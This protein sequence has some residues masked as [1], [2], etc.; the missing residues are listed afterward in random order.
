MADVGGGAGEWWSWPASSSDPSSISDCV[1]TCAWAQYRRKSN[2]SDGN[3][4]A[5]LHC[6]AN[7]YVVSNTGSHRYTHA[8]GCPHSYADHDSN[9]DLNSF[10]HTDVDADA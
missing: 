7:T 3:A 8:D 1:S 5:N 2:G 4:E 10:G 9:G 6:N